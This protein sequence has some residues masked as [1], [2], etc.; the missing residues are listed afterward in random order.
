MEEFKIVDL[1]K[2]YTKSMVEEFVDNMGENAPPE[3]REM[4]R[5]NL[6][7]NLTDSATPILR[8]MIDYAIGAACY[9]LTTGIRWARQNNKE[10]K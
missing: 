7:Y 6:I 10:V 2:E 5:N 1:L 8:G 4:H 3:L 9:R